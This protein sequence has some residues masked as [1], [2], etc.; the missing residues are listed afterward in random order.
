MY[1]IV[2]NAS[3]GSKLIY[4]VFIAQIKYTDWIT[5]KCALLNAK[6]KLY[7]FASLF[8]CH[9]FIYRT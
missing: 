8:F 5:E 7:I 1:Q 2:P 4:S 3:K 6:K 9:I